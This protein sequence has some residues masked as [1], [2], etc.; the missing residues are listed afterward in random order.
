MHHR[1]QDERS[2]MM[3]REAV[4]MLQE[5]DILIADIARLLDE[6]LQ[7]LQAMLSDNGVRVRVHLPTPPPAPSAPEANQSTLP[8]AP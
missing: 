7:M 4:R 1:L 5:T 8:P 6:L 3:H 2:L